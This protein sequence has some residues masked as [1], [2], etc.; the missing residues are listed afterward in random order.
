MVTRNDIA[1]LVGIGLLLFASVASAQDAP[2][3]PN[4]SGTTSDVPGSA[5]PPPTADSDSDETPADDETETQRADDRVPK[6]APKEVGTWSVRVDVLDGMT[7]EPITNTGVVLKASRPRGPF[8]SKEPE[9][10][11]TWEGVTDAQGTARFEGL[12]KAALRRGLELYAVTTHRGI[13]FKS[14]R[15]TPHDGAQLEIRVYPRAS[16]ADSVKVEQ[17]RT[18]A[19]PWEDYLVFTQFWQLTVDGNKVVDTSTLPGKEY[20][21]GLPIEL[22]LDAK[23]ISAFGPGETKV[24]DS[25]VNWK[26]VLRPGET[27]SLR[28]RFSMS[29]SASTFVYR[30][31]VDFPTESVEVVLPLQTDTKKVKL[32]YLEDAELAA[33]G[34]EEVSATRD[35][36]GFRSD[37]GYLYARG[38]SLEAGESFAVQFRGLPF[39]P[40]IAPW[41]TLGLGVLG[42]GLVLVFARRERDIFESE[43]GRADMIDALESDRDTL[44]DELAE[45]E[46]AWDEDEITELTYETESL[47][48]RERLS[49][50]MKK[51]DELRPSEQASDE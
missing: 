11:K 32:G 41:V 12:Q 40:P 47:R 6:K 26:G 31:A 35:V 49:L 37:K 27:V 39:D 50:I 22:P 14:T 15:N 36:P 43:E 34:F 13:A 48:L 1:S 5:N 19:E 28:V 7:D 18:V 8:E 20:E 4:P 38:K 16:N 51:L 10:V 44:L 30:Q 46:R 3:P 45:L 42:I 9:P 24:V 29:A 25:T 17:L 23:G 2:D 33:K 21:K